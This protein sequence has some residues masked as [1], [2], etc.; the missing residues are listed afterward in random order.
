[1]TKCLTYPVLRS[2]L[3][4]GGILLIFS[5]IARVLCNQY[6]IFPLFYLTSHDVGQLCFV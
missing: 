5:K 1:M 2:N 3:F 6:D 4:G